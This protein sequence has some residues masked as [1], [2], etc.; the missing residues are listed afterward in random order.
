MFK[1]QVMEL[2]IFKILNWLFTEI[3]RWEKD[4]LIPPTVNAHE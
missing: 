4:T 3:L 1:L 2:F